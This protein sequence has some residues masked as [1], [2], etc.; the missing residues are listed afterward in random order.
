MFRLKVKSY[1]SFM[2]EM[3]LSLSLS[4]ITAMFVTFLSFSIFRIC[5]FYYRPFFNSPDCFCYRLFGLP[6]NLYRTS[7]Q[8]SRVSY[9]GENGLVI[10]SCISWAYILAICRPFIR[11][12]HKIL[13]KNACLH[14]RFVMRKQLTKKRR[15]Q[16]ER[17]C[18]NKNRIYEIKQIDFSCLHWPTIT[19]CF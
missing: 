16:R 4:F 8:Y 19:F 6:A 9:S 17:D 2:L 10:T 12:L 3:E 15:N 7:A 5:N 18:N 13:K 14:L 1:L 11:F